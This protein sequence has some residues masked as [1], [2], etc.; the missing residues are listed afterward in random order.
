MWPSPGCGRAAPTS[1]TTRRTT[2]RSSSSRRRCWT[3]WHSAPW[4][5]C[6]TSPQRTMAR[7][8]VSQE[9][10]KVIIVSIFLLV[11]KIGFQTFY[12]RSVFP[13][14]YCHHFYLELGSNSI[15]HTFKSRRT[16]RPLFSFHFCH[17]KQH[18]YDWGKNR[19]V[20][21]TTDHHPI[22]SYTSLTIDL[23]TNQIKHSAIAS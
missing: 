10:Q 23:Q 16:D 8:S 4:C 15:A 2:E 13:C 19:A 3:C 9:I 7:T 6:T 17:G 18:V 20:F 11:V 14:V 1:P 21:T 22:T 5:W 12:K